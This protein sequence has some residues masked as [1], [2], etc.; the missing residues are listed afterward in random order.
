MKKNIIKIM[1]IV[2]AFAFILTG[3]ATVGNIPNPNKELIYNG[4]GVV[5]VGSHLYFGNAYTPV[6]DSDTGFAYDDNAKISYMNRLNLEGDFGTSEN[7]ESP[8]GS[9]KVNKKVVGYEN[10]YMFVLGDYIY[11]TSANTHKSSSLENKYK[12]VSFFRSKLNGDGLKEIFTTNQFDSANGK[13]TTMQAKDGNY[14]LVVFDGQELST[15][16]LGNKLGKRKVICKEVL[17]VALPHESDE[18]TVR[19]IYYTTNHKGEDGENTSEIDIFSVDLVSGESVKRGNAGRGAN[20]KFLDRVGDTVFYTNSATI[21]G[22][23]ECYYEDISRTQ[24]F[25][26]G[27]RFYA[28]PSISKVMLVSP[29]DPSSEGYVFVSNGGIMYKNTAQSNVGAQLLLA[30]SNYSDVLFVK[31]DYVYCSNTSGIYRISVKNKSLETVVELESL[32]SGKVS[33]AGDYLYFYAGLK[34]DEEE[35]TEGGEEN[36]DEEKVEYEE[37][38]NSYMYRVKLDGNGGYQMLSTYKRVEK[39]S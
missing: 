37:D 8:K 23:N 36:S 26:G 4:G 9:E 34:I 32:V 31:C 39:K 14:Y 2:C 27:N 1:T 38:N 5:Q 20:V 18:Y 29:N 7:Y 22:A 13:I 28:N 30:N 35:S 11:F 12:L 25:T 19:E 6:G 3:C 16:K 33:Y 15:I 17:S 24:T 21:G 10:Q